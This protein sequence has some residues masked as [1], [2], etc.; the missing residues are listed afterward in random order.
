MALEIYWGS[1][2]PFAWRVLLA[3]EIKQ[4]PYESKLLSLSNAEHKSDE[5]LAISPRGKVPAIRDGDITVHESI[6]IIQYIDDIKPE[7]AIFGNTPAERSQVWS[8]IMEIM[9]Y[10]EPHIVDFARPI[11]FGYL[12]K[13]Q[14]SVTKARQA[15]EEELSNIDQM[16]SSKDYLALDQLTAADIVMYPIIPFLARAAEKESTEAISGTLLSINEHYP[17]IAAWCKKI[18]T[19]PGY[20]NT[21]PPH[22]KE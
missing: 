21:Y 15:I 2:S 19:I 20:E 13:K 9:N 7:P 12:E 1:G 3:L 6:A 10:I 22:W 4:L 11:F 14:A 18:E 16:L 5:F 17:A 8:A